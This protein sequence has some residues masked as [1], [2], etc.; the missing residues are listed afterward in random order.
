MSFQRSL[1]FGAGVT[2]A[3]VALATACSST[4][5][6]PGAE[7]TDASSANDTAAP[8]PTPDANVP[9]DS[10]SPDT[11]A[12]DTSAPDAGPDDASTDAGPGDAAPD[13]PTGAVVEGPDGV[14]RGTVSGTIEHRWHGSL[15]MTNPKCPAGATVVRGCCEWDGAFVS[16]AVTDVPVTF[17]PATRTGT[18]AGSP[19]GPLNAGPTSPTGVLSWQL[20]SASHWGKGWRANQAIGVGR[21]TAATLADSQAFFALNIVNEVLMSLSLAT[22]TWDPANKILTLREAHPLTPSGGSCQA[23]GRTSWDLTSP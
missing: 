17:D 14:L 7:P 6:G 13:A 8:V 23:N 21:E 4:T 18:L 5:P 12:P 20:P 1:R 9:R 16:T 19:I 2:L 11:S 22:V 10:A 15:V 3:L